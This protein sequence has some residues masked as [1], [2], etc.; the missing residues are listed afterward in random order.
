MRNQKDFII[1]R[2]ISILSVFD[3]YMLLQSRSFYKNTVK[4][5]VEDETKTIS[6]SGNCPDYFQICIGEK[7]SVLEM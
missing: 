4:N 6:V 3:G 7:E 1:G 2:I 5:D